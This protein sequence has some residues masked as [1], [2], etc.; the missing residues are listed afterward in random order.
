MA[1][2]DPRQKTKKRPGKFEDWMN[3]L[4]DKLEAWI[5]SS[6]WQPLDRWMSGLIKHMGAYLKENAVVILTLVVIIVSAYGFELFN[7]NLSIDEEVHAFYT[8]PDVWIREGRWGIYLMRKIFF[9]YAILPFM[10]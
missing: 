10:P 2:D 4:S 9:P 6:I 5:K 7:F 1:Q 3:K 8:N